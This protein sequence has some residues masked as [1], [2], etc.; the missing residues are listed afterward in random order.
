MLA[1]ALLAA[2]SV[3]A[4]SLAAPAGVRAGIPPACSI[5]ISSASS[6]VPAETAT[7]IVDEPVQVA[8]T[9]FLPDTELAITVNFNGVDQATFP[10]MT[11][12][13]GNFLL[14]GSLTEDQ[15]GDWILTAAEPDQGCSDF[16]TF[17][18]VMP[19]ESPEGL[20]DAAMAVEDRWDGGS[21]FAIGLFI[22]AVV[23]LA[24]A[25][26]RSRRPV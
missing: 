12:G 13:S 4:L 6:P 26:A 25:S 23:A 3:L 14:T 1:A 11:D 21:A 8:G 9:G 15:V 2:A 5:L 10:Q 16:V 22:V 24:I 7:I 17:A 19:A 18:V 20:P